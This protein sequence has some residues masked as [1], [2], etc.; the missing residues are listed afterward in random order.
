MI[1]ATDIVAGD[2]HPT[3]TD[4]VGFLWVPL[5]L[6][7]VLRVPVL[8]ITVINGA[9]AMVHMNPILLRAAKIITTRK[10][11]S[12]IKMEQLLIFHQSLMADMIR[13]SQEV[14]LVQREPMNTTKRADSHLAW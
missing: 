1:S 5:Q 8:P 4:Q 6:L 13:P 11:T 9:T 10:I 2:L 12:T 7:R 3:T 14:I